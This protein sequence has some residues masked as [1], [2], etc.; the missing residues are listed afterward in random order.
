MPSPIP[1]SVKAAVK[2]D[3][4]AGLSLHDSAKAHGVSPRKAQSWSTAEG[5]AKLKAA[6][7][8]GP[9]SQLAPNVVTFERPRSAAHPATI[10][11]IL[12]ANLPDVSD[13]RAVLDRSIARLDVMI[14]QPY[15]LRT[16]GGL[17][18]ALTRAVETRRKISSTEEL[19]GQLLERFPNPRDLLAVLKAGPWEPYVKPQH[20]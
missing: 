17:V 3:Y 7:Q 20:R 13:L 14:Q 1:D 4:F 15:D 8:A 11:L 6:A 2:R 18:T 5:W 16:M 10:E 12:D 9:P 19:L